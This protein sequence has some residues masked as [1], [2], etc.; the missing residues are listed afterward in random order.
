MRTRT[1]EEFITLS[2]CLF[3]AISQAKQHPET[4]YGYLKE[5]QALF[6]VIEDML[7]RNHFEFTEEEEGVAHQE[8]QILSIQISALEKKAY[9]RRLKGVSR[10]I[11]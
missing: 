5:A 1:N 11:A 4:V 7:F 3:T 10:L 8:M 2:N 6:D 9:G